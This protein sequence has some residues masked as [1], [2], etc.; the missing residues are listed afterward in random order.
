MSELEAPR[1]ILFDLDGTLIDSLP[2]LVR[3]A[4]AMRAA[5]GEPPLDRELVSRFV[6]NG[7]RNL[8]HRVL[9]GRIDGQADASRF[10]RGFAIFR[11][12]YLEGCCAE[13]RLR[14][15]AVETLAALRGRGIAC[16]VL[17]NKSEAP[18]RRIL[19]H[20]GLAPHLGAAIGGDTEFGRKPDPVGAFE[21]ARRMGVDPRRDHCWLVGDSMTDLRTAAA[22][23]MS[24]VAIRGGYH[25]GDPFERCDPRPARVIETLAELVGLAE[26][27]VARAM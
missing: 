15:G 10:E 16:G 21:A 9:T 14:P 11:S 7:V 2:D 19:E 17:T 27:P 25:H 4:N 1:A 24:A 26:M 23:G 12:I 20:Y 8:V 3:S 6:G 22:A 13:S 5:L 18:M